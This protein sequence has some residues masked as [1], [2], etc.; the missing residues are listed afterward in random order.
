MISVTDKNNLKYGSTLILSMSIAAFD[1]IIRNCS[2][3]A[4]NKK[5]II[6]VKFTF[7]IFA[8]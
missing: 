3:E 6:V 8:E 5:I 1:K 7:D 2:A 4:K